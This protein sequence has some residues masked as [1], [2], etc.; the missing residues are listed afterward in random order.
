MQPDIEE[1]NA[2]PVS[3]RELGGI[4]MGLLMLLFVNLLFIV[5]TELSISR[6]ESQQ[7]SQDGLWTFGQTLALLLLLLPLWN[8][9]A[10]LGIVDGPEDASIRTAAV[11]GLTD[12]TSNVEW[13]KVQK[14][15][16]D[17]QDGQKGAFQCPQDPMSR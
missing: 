14:W 10:T 15:I 8:V 11:S 13:L 6:N 16:S 9:A 12:Y 4:V 3:H 17:I 5:D 2:A 7:G 1:E